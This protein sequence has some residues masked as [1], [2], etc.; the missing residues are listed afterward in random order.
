MRW[1][2]N[3]ARQHLVASRFKWQQILSS[4]FKLL[5]CPI[6][7]F[8]LDSFSICSSNAP[9]LLNGFEIFPYVLL[10]YLGRSIFKLIGLCLFRYLRF[11]EKSAQISDA[12]KFSASQLARQL[13]SSC[14]VENYNGFSHCVTAIFPPFS[15][16]HLPALF[17]RLDSPTDWATNPIETKRKQLIWGLMGYKDERKSRRY[18][19]GGDNEQTPGSKSQGVSYVLSFIRIFL[20]FKVYL[21][22]L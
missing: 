9:S 2:P 20:K 1:L 14:F 7:A 5:F 15:T 21:L 18:V 3:A 17:H 10:S 22:L 13:M 12:P 11:F 19:D 8:Q 6:S 16:S 4:V